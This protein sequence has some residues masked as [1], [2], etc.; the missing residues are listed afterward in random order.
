M[1]LESIEKVTSICGTPRGAGGMPTR[2]NLPSDL[3]SR[4]NSRS[5]CSTCTVHLVLIVGDGREDQ[6]V[7]G[8]D[9]RVALDHLREDAAVRLDA[10]RQRRDVEQDH[11]LDVAAQN[12]GLHGGADGDDFVGIDVAVR[13]LAEAFCTA[14]MTR[15]MRV[16]PPTRTTSSM[17]V[18]VT[19]AALSASL[20][21]SIVCWIRSSTIFSNS[22]RVR[23]LFRCFGPEASAEMNGSVMRDSRSNRK[24]VLGALRR[25]L[26]TLQGH[27]VVGEADAG[28]ALEAFDEPVDDALV[29]I[30]A[31]EVRVAGRGEDFEETIFELEDRDVERAAAEVVDGDDAGSVLFSRPYASAAA[32]GSLMMRSTSRPAIL[33]ASRVAWRWLSLKYAGTVMMASVTGSPRKSSANDLISISTNAEISSGEYSRSRIFTFMSPLSAGTI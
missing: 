22:R 17:S 18:G 26:Q 7:L 30:F 33:P 24:L 1:P 32:V 28:L 6:R 8:R 2:S 21:G 20:T 16:W 5:P 14:S 19:P 25:F 31:A 12:A 27:A 9:R 10:E 15:G 13:L 11:V 3:L 29:E 23:T 4:A